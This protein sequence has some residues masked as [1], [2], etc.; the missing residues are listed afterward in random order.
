LQ[1][2]N[3]GCSFITLREPCNN[4]RLR[5]DIAWLH[6]SNNIYL[7]FGLKWLNSEICGIN[8]AYLNVAIIRLFVYLICR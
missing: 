4:Q 8:I 6:V 7:G 5:C 1:A 2:L 3:L